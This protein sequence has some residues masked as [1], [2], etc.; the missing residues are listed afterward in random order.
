[1]AGFQVPDGWTVQ[2]YRF[3]LDPT[4]AQE[5]V[6]VSHAGAARKAFNVMLAAVKANLDQR[7]TAP[8]GTEVDRVSAPKPL[9]A[10]E[11]ELARLQRRAARRTGPWDPTARRRRNAS[12]RW[13]RAQAQVARTHARVANLRRHALHEATT[14][15][16]Q[17]HSVI[18]IEDL[19]VAGMSR[20]GG[21]RKRGLN[22]ALA[23][24][25]LARLRT[26]LDYK[27][28]WY[29]AALVVAD[30]WFASTQSCSSCGAK[31]KLPLAERLYC[32][33]S[34]GLVID[35]DHNAAI[36]LARLGDTTHT[37][38]GMGTGTGSGPA[39]NVSVG[40]GRGADRKT[41]P[42]REV[43]KAGGVEASTPHGPLAGRTGTA[44][45]QG[46]AA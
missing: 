4:P 22:R 29:G 12:K 42:T 20:G 24:A 18:V 33:G 13:K 37:G 40:Q 2:G 6:L 14:A 36:N 25:S 34:C 17:Q 5:Q 38:G 16:A 1:M 46:T 44:A 28:R 21:A 9:K 43:G 3:A 31:T 41:R 35:R 27:C 10:A 30:R 15:L 23:D 32:C 39:A 45:P 11:A 26:M 7:V 8:D 19:N